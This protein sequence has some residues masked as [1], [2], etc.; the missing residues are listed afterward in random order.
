MNYKVPFVNYPL[1]YKNIKKEID[2]A[3]KRILEEGDLIYRQDLQKFEKIFAKLCQ[4][5]Y[6]I[7]TGSC[8]GALFISLQAMGVGPGDE[9]ITVAHTYVATIDVIVACGATPILVDIRDDFNI[10]PDLLEKAIT[11]KTKA[12]IPVHLNGRACEMDKI[13]KIAK[14]HNLV[15]IEDAAQ[16]VG[17][18]Y[19]NKKAGSFGLTGCFSFYPAKLLGCYGEGGM[20]VA[21][22]KKIAE[23]LYLLRDHG[24]NPSYLLSE[25]EKGQGYKN[26]YFF[27]FNTILDNMQAAFL[28]IKI[29]YLPKWLE[30]R[31]QIAEMYN[32]GLNN[33]KGLILPPAPAKSPYYDV[34]QNYVIRTEKR[35]NLKKYLNKTGVETLISWKIPNHKQKGL[36][37]LNKF[38]LPKTE[39]IS[40]E[41]LSLPM[42]PELTDSQVNYTIK[43]IRNFYGK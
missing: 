27:G 18:K 34:Y 37:I 36:K 30:R 26:L 8:T 14:K 1:Q 20:A 4:T 23:K 7:S 12:I 39:Q 22:N 21:N 35:D 9:V 24:E 13:M 6:G 41:V 28:N 15:V 2:S 33:V 19:K 25:T 43:C 29:K 5:K 16:A 42:Y 10:N 31:R 38:K 11:K 3:F 32:N 40:R 17:A